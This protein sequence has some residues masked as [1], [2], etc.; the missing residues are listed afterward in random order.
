MEARDVVQWGCSV[1]GAILARIRCGVY[2]GMKLPNKLGKLLSSQRR[3]NSA[4]FSM[5]I[6]DTE[7]DNWLRITMTLMAQHLHRQTI[8]CTTG[9]WVLAGG[10]PQKANELVDKG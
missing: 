9:R 4:L 3:H 2:L 7:E 1:D 10:K 6:E 5:S 8:L